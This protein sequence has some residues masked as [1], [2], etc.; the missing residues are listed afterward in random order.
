M[1]WQA[2][3]NRMAL[4]LSRR[5]GNAVTIGSESGYGFLRSPEEKVYDGM[6][7]L[8]NYVLEFPA[9]TWPYVAEGTAI[10]V[11]EIT[12]QS[13]EESRPNRDRSSILIPLRLALLGGRR[14]VTLSGDVL[15]TLDGNNLVTI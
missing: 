10:I 13:R 9:L 12:Y 11:D 7:F 1:T 3:A 6:V 14:L 15:I 8:T 2:R 5:L 4:S